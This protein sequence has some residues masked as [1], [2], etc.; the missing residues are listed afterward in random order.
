MGRWS[1][2]KDITTCSSDLYQ[3]QPAA[4]M[5]QQQYMIT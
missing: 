5:G 1:S 2:G 4:A 3:Q